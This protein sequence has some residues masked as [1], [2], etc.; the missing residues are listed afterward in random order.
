M[1]TLL[2]YRWLQIVSTVVLIVALLI[3]IYAEMQKSAAVR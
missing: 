2:I 1:K 3:L